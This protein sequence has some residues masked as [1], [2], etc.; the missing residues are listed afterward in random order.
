MKT[1]EY[2][3][4]NNLKKSDLKGNKKKGISLFK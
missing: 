2:S 4:E 1:L 3:P